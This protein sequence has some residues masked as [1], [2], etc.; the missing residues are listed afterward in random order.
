MPRAS[1]GRGR[2]HLG[3]AGNRA[4]A[5][6]WLAADR[7]RASPAYAQRWPLVA[8]TLPADST[9]RRPTLTA[10]S[11]GRAARTAPSHLMALRARVTRRESVPAAAWEA[12]WEELLPA[13]R[14]PEV[15]AS[16]LEHERVS[17]RRHFQGR[18]A[19][20][21]SSGRLSAGMRK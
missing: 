8:T 12:R 17:V 2:R 7:R 1:A 18:M 15:Q 9:L 10:A 11:W 21:S 5:D 13:R 14:E 4:H 6:F 20:A 16:R 3:A 19:R